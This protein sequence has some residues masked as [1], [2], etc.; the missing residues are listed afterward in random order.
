MSFQGVQSSALKISIINTTISV[1]PRNLFH[2]IG[3]AYNLTIDI[4][5][6]NKMIGSFP[7]PHT[8]THLNMEDQVYLIDLNL[9][10]VS[11]SCDCEIGWVEYWQRLRRQHFCSSQDWPDDI[12]VKN[13]IESNI[14]CDEIYPDDEDYR[15]VRC[16]NKNSETLLEVLKNELECGWSGASSNHV[17]LIISTIVTFALMIFLV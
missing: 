14:E 17:N 12:D 11:F 2:K 4:D 1:L 9:H 6:N 10:Y 15:L 3:D 5:S 8:A 13:Q 7:N 16:S